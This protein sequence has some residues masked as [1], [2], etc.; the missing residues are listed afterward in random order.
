M[1]ETDMFIQ[2]QREMMR[3]AT[4]ARRIRMIITIIIVVDGRI[5]LF[6]NLHRETKTNTLRV[7]WYAPYALR[8]CV[9]ELTRTNGIGIN[10]LSTACYIST[11]E[12]D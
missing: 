3:S 11:I 2:I 1:I 6:T 12:Y 8:V 10:Y 4:V 5:R 9:L 7:R